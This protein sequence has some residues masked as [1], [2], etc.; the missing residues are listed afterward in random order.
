MGGGREPRRRSCALLVEAGADVNARSTVLE[1]PVLE[2]PRSGGPNSPFPRGGWTALMFAA[3]EGSIDAARA[4][5]GAGADLNAVALPQTDVPLK[6]EELDGRD[7][8]RRHDGAGLRHHQLA[9]RSGGDAAR[10]GRR[11]ERA[12][13][14]GM[15][16]LYAAVDMNSLQWAQGRPAPIFT[17][18]LDAVDLVKLLLAEGRQPERAAEARAAQAPPRRRHDAQLRRGRD[19]ADARRAHQRRRRDEAAARRAAPIRS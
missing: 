17:D 2:F 6:P 9:L 7:R 8:G 1:A 19:A 5:A 4:L 12:D 13:L 11:S 14:A 18:T 15:A 16:A 3:R 10:E